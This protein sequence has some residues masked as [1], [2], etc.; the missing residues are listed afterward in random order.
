MTTSKYVSRITKGVLRLVDES[1]SKLDE[2]RLSFNEYFVLMF[3]TESASY[4]RNYTFYKG[5]SNYNDDYQLHD[6]EFFKQG[7]EHGYYIS[8][9]YNRMKNPTGRLMIVDITPEN[10]KNC[11]SLDI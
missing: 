4:L 10:L 5:N 8:K 11:I 3:F 7:L 9:H 2:T 1:P 6:I